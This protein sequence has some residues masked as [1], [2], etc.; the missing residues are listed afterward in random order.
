M[1]YLSFPPFTPVCACSTRR[2]WSVAVAVLLLAMVVC[3][4]QSA[5]AQGDVAAGRIAEV[6]TSHR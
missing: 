5:I 1:R 4:P 2:K 3:A 6:S